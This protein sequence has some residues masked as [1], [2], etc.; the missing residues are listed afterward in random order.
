MIPVVDLK[1]R[2]GDV[3]RKTIKTDA[4]LAAARLVIK[5]NAQRNFWY[6]CY[7]V[8][9]FQDIATNIHLTLCDRYQRRFLHNF[10]IYLLPRGH[11]KTTL[12]TVAGTIWEAVQDE[13][14]LPGGKHIRGQNLRVLIGNAKLELA[15]DIVRDIENIVATNEMFAWLF[16][17]YV[18]SESWRRGKERG[19]WNSERLDWP[20]SAQAGRKEGCVQII[21]AG[22]SGT[23]KHFD[24]LKFD[25]VVNDEN[26][27]TKALRDKMDRWYKNILQLR[28]DPV[29][30]RVCLIGTRWHY[31][32]QYGRLIR[33]EMARREIAKEKG[34]TVKPVYFI[35]RRKAKENGIPIWGERFTNEELDR[36]KYDELGSYIYSCQYDNDPVPEEDAHFKRNH[37]KR[38][39]SLDIPNNLVHFAA[40]D[41]ADEETTRGDFTVVTIASFDQQARMYVRQIYRGRYTQYELLQ[42]V[43]MLHEKWGLQRVGVETTGFQKSLFRGYKSESARNGWYIPWMEVERGKTSKFKRTLGLQPRVERGDF[44][45]EES[46]DNDEWAIEEMLTFPKGVHDDILDTLVDLENIYYAAGTPEEPEEVKPVNTYDAYIGPLADILDNVEDSDF[47][48]VSTIL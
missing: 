13:L 43:H 31:D 48:S 1:D 34:E 21:S 5:R 45:I 19:K 37:I 14:I 35:Y 12:L 18:P 36:L 4:D 11:L 30:S 26:I 27:D 47:L 38:I 46:I 9:G 24:V 10:N 22:A 3:V 15:I 32:D 6:F 2:I 29:S 44:Y 16:P 33:K 40:V 28:N 17:E 23:S 20:C 39:D 7:H 25:D 8:C 42:L 41:L